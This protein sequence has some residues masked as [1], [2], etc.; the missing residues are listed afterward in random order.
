MTPEPPTLKGP[1]RGFHISPLLEELMQVTHGECPNKH[2]ILLAGTTQVLK[3]T[4]G[5]E[6][7]GPCP[8]CEARVTYHVR[9]VSE[10][11][12]S[13]PSCGAKIAVGGT[14]LKRKET[15]K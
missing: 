2:Y 8:F 9:L 4:P 5:E 11:F 7:V 3:A 10:V 6:W 13:V 1:W 12:F 15:K 14:P